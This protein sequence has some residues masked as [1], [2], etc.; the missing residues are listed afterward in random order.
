MVPGWFPPPLISPPA[1]S[2][3]IT[4]PIINPKKIVVGEVGRLDKLAS[5]NYVIINLKEEG[6]HTFVQRRCLP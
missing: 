5:N 2:G 3:G 1:K 4:A 6:E